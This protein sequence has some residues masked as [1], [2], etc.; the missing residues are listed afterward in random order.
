MQTADKLRKSILQAAIQGRLTK[1]LPTDG[2]AKDLLAQIKAEKEEL[3]AEGKIKKEKPLAP[4]TDDEKPFE[5]PENWEWVRHNTVFE[6]VGGSQPP[7]SHFSNVMKTGYVRLYQIRD[8]GESPI[9][10][11]VSET[12]VSKFTEKNDILLARYGGSL[13]KVFFAEKGAYN[14]AMAKVVP[15]FA[16]KE[17]I[18]IKFM[19]NYYLAPLYQNLVRAQ[20]RG[21]QAGFNKDDLNTLL[22]PLP[23]L[24]EQKRIVERVEELFAEVEKLE[25]DEK[26]LEEIQKTFPSKMKNALLQSAIQG[27]LT[28]QLP[29]DGSAKDLLGKIKPISEDEIPFDIPENWTW[30][31]LGDMC[32]IYNG[33]SINTQEKAMK[34]SKHNHNTYDYIGTKDVGFDHVISYDNGVYI[35]QTET[36]FK[37]APTNSVL[38]CMEG[39]SAGKKIAL[40]TKDIC[41]G[42]KLCCFITD[43]IS[44]KYVYYYLQTSTFISDFKDSMT[45]IIGGVGVNKI[46]NIAIA[47]PPLAEQKRI[48]EKLEEL[49]PLC[50]DLTV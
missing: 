24:A 39:G 49:L 12:L 8:Y 16:S 5:I 3:I 31:R 30:V 40:V 1:Q 35:P 33:N 6:I 2:S 34:Y 44:N 28:E 25:R 14:V 50:E 27:K 22:I 47:L 45:G 11:Y 17:L 38:L 32:Q 37:V 42:N 43:I 36:K 48:V 15:L 13:G 46:K 19:Y 9:P 20:T 23:P 7:K 21:A 10:V 41:F 29:T 18:N 26:Q 4:I